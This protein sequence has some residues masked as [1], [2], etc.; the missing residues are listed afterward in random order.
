MLT[1]PSF[2]PPTTIS[3]TRPVG[4]RSG[5]ARGSVYLVL[6][7]PPTEMVTPV[8]SWIFQSMR[9]SAPDGTYAVASRA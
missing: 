2:A 6:G 9:A 5:R 7:P 1:E 3:R 4:R 8:A